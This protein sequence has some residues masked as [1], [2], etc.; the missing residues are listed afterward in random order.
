M[1]IPVSELRATQPSTE[2]EIEQRVVQF[3]SANPEQAYA[4]RELLEGVLSRSADD[5]T[6]FTLA[7]LAHP[8]LAETVGNVMTKLIFGRQVE[9]FDRDGQAYFAYRVPA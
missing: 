6:G 8:A 3:L 9:V 2:G 7:L 4:F 5:S 1:P